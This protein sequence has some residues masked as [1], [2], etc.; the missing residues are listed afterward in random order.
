MN[1]TDTCETAHVMHHGQDY[2]APVNRCKA[3]SRRKICNRIANQ[4]R[5]KGGGA[6]RI[7]KASL[8]H[9]LL[10]TSEDQRLTIYLVHAKLGFEKGARPVPSR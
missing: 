4:S 2:A 9:P 8:A 7:D 10:Y 5:V 3:S 6:R 1:S